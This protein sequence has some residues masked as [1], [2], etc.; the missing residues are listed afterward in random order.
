M[1]E[2]PSMDQLLLDRLN[3]TIEH[4]L[5]NEQ[6]GVTELANEAVLSKSH[7]FANPYSS[8]KPPERDAA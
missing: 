3:E 5:D 1:K 6:F 4:N 2:H 7:V 8:S